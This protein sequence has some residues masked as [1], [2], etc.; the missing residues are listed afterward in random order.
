MDKYT[1]EAVGLLERLISVPSVSR[2]EGAA[3]AKIAGFIEENGFSLLRVGNNVASVCPDF[4]DTLPTLLLDA[5]IDTVKPVSGWN[6]DPYAP[7]IEDGCLYGLGANDDGGSL[8]SLMQAYFMITR[9]KRG[10][11]VV[12]SASAEEEV[13]GKNGIEL[14]LPRLPHVDAGIIGE[15]T[16]LQPAVA[17]KGLMVIDVTSYGRSGHAARNEGDNAI[18]KAV[19][20]I[21]WIKDHEFAKVSPLLGKVKATV[22]IINAGTQHNVIPDRCVFTVDVRSNELYSNREIFDEIRKN[23]KS[24]PVARSFRLNSSRIDESHPL[25]RRA[26]DMGRTPFGSPTLSNQ[27]LLSFPTVK[28]GPGESS[29]S[30]TADEYIKISEIEES[31]EFFVSYLKGLNMDELKRG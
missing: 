19:E 3:A 4:D 18:Y 22:T 10:F 8:V 26:K 9:E 7:V 16:A 31:I 5:H 14:L 15:P 2:D 27:A 25:V 30:H 21:R 12:F 6:R 24:E 20:D 29:R 1:K 11:N 23:I 17:E 28:I 13:S